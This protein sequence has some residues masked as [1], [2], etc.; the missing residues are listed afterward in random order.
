MCDSHLIIMPSICPS[1]WYL[2]KIVKQK[3][4]IV[5]LTQYRAKL[6]AK[7][8]SPNLAPNSAFASQMAWLGFFLYEFS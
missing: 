8:F 3:Q 5:K 2:M 6:D 4:K 7:L 1:D